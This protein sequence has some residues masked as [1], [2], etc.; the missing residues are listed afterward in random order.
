MQGPKL[1]HG[2]G[3]IDEE[4]VQ[5]FYLSFAGDGGIGV[6]VLFL[7]KEAEVGEGDQSVQLFSFS[8]GGLR[9][10]LQDE[11]F[12]FVEGAHAHAGET[13]VAL[14]LLHLER[15]RVLPTQFEGDLG[16]DEL[17][18]CLP[19]HPVLP[20]QPL[21]FPLVQV[22]FFRRLQFLPEAE[23]CPTDCHPFA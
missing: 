19:S 21:P 2:D 3:D 22:V 23:N 5:S 4:F 11:G 17:G 13:H 18:Q 16:G 1:L 20:G 12:E 7:A 15:V 6:G 14:Q 8:E 10:Y 9:P